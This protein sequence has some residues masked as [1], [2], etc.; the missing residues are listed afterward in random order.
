MSLF[1]HR[2]IGWSLLFTIY[3]LCLLEGFQTAL[4]GKLDRG[5]LAQ[6]LSKGDCTFINTDSLSVLSFWPCCAL[7]LRHLPTL[8]PWK[9]DLFGDASVV[10][11]G[12]LENDW[13]F[14]WVNN[15]LQY[16]NG[17]YLFLAIS[18]SMVGSF[19]V[20]VFT[21]NLLSAFLLPF[22][23]HKTCI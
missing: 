16:T 9:D 11:L 12:K 23:V 18:S 10:G 14:N 4:S 1:Y 6:F 2:L 21:K 15:R 8:N 20:R 7:I 17:L 5:V 19:R 22:D 3:K 13:Y